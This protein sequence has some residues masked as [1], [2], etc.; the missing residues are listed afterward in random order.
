MSE[1]QDFG[2]YLNEYG[3]DI[4][5]DSYELWAEDYTFESHSA[6]EIYELVKKFLIQRHEEAMKQRAIEFAEF[7]EAEG[8]YRESYYLDAEDAY[9]EK[10]ESDDDLYLD[11][12]N[13]YNEKYGSDAEN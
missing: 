1:I 9:N 8:E 6:R 13:A 2:K 3:Y 12:K 10:Y 5:I 11:P 4:D 7:W